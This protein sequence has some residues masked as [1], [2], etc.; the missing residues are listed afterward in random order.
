MVGGIAFSGAVAGAPDALRYTITAI[1]MMSATPTIAP[2]VAPAMTPADVDPEL[3]VLL[4]EED[5][6]P[7]ASVVDVGVRVG[8]TEGER[9]L[10]GGREEDEDGEAPKESVCVGVCDAVADCV[11]DAACVAV[12]VGVT[13]SVGVDSVSGQAAVGSK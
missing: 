11:S 8:V 13:A 12:C 1:M 4:L 3:L 2:T 10:E 6:T 7:A 5:E 9:V